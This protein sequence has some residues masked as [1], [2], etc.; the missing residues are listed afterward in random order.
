MAR[1]RTGTRSRKRTRTR[2]ARKYSKKMAKR[3][4]KSRRGSRMKGGSL[5]SV[6]NKALVPAALFTASKA[7]QKR[8]KRKSGRMN[9]KKLK[10]TL[11]NKRRRCT[12]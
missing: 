7:L 8:S 5:M 10:N 1:R 3:R 9:F 4:G 12:R 11:R 6:L 2:V